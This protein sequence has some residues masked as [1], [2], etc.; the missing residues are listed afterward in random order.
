MKDVFPFWK[1]RE[2]ALVEKVKRDGC[3]PLQ[4]LMMSTKYISWFWHR[5]GAITGTHN[6]GLGSHVHGVEA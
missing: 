6:P 5:F 4:I 3:E 1:L 2:T